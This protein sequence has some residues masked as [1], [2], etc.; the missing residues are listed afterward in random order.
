M[1][2]RWVMLIFLFFVKLTD[3]II[4]FVYLYFDSDRKSLNTTKQKNLK[5]PKAVNLRVISSQDA[6]I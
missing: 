5:L 1:I 2:T 3:R 4:F 6:K